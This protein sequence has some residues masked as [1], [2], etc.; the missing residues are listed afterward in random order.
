MFKFIERAFS[1]RKMNSMPYDKKVRIVRTCVENIL[2]SN[3]GLN[4]PIFQRVDSVM[5]FIF[6]RRLVDYYLQNRKMIP[7]LC[8]ELNCL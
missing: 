6:Q 4:I 5:E 3:K 2:K 8:M 1:Q 7:V